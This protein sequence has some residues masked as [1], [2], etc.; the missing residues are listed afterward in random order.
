MEFDGA[1]IREQGLTFAIAIVKPSVI[2]NRAEASRVINDF[3]QRVFG[4]MPVVLMAQDGFGTP[5]Y[6]GRDDIVNF[7]ASVPLDAIPW[8]R[9]TLN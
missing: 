1:V 3:Q 4:N 6:L 2:A 9:Y 8:R 5:T 7:L